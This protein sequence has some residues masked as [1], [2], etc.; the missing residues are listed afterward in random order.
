MLRAFES[1]ERTPTREFILALAGALHVDVRYF[2]RTDFP[3]IS[4]D[5][6]EL[7]KNSCECVVCSY[8]ITGNSMG[9]ITNALWLCP[10]E[11]AKQICSHKRTRGKKHFLG[12]LYAN[13]EDVDSWLEDDGRYDLTLQELGLR[14]E[15]RYVVKNKRSVWVADA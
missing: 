9:Q 12:W 8:N 2:T 7:D 10:P 13:E 3:L 11:V 15:G 14:K 6:D 5:S 4:P 1:G